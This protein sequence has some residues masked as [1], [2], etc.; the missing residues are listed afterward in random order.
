MM[1]GCWQTNKPTGKNK[2]MKRIQPMN[3]ETL[4]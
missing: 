4:D 1:T 3:S 2:Q